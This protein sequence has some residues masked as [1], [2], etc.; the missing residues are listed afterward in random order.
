MPEY[1]EDMQRRR[2]K[3]EAMKRKQ[4]A[5]ARRLRLT[6]I[7]A[8]LILAGAAFGIYTLVQKNDAS[9]A[10]QATEPEETEEETQEETSDIL[11][12]ITV[13]HV[14]AAGDLN[15]TDSVIASGQSATGYDYTAAFRDVAAVLSEA[16][17]TVM[18]FEG[19]IY[20]TPYGTATSSA[21]VEI[22]TALRNAGVDMLQIANSCTIN[23]GLNGLNS[24]IQAIRNAGIE[25]LGAYATESEFKQYKG[26]TITEVR[27]VKIAFVAF[28]KGMSGRGMPVGSENLVNLLYEDYADEYQTVDEKRITQILKNAAAERPDLTVAL[29]HWGSEYNDDLSRSQQRIVSLMKKQ[30]VDVILGTHPHLVQR[31]DFDPAA[32]TLVAYSL[33]DFFGDAERGG[34][35][36]SIILDIEIT[37]DSAAGTTKVTGFD[38]TPIYTVKPSE[39][40]GDYRISRVMRID[41]TLEAYNGNFLDRV[42]KTC[43]ENMKFAQ[44][45]IEARLKMAMT[46]E[47]RDEEAKKAKEA[48]EASK[49]AETNG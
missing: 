39:A 40:E 9:H 12:P 41:K 17:L 22:L 42:T 15:V 32:G 38:Y 29:V 24:T 36:Y 47:E 34:T 48:K 1:D 11:D 30:G 49:A 37:K 19:N 20:G 43:S 18:N 5:R 7:L 2:E 31:I 23:N 21:P 45:R 8:L 25:P 27:G 3:R 16:D 28:T 46:E 33:G 4:K 13:L 10:L 44:T 14:R 26:Y 6:L 35:S